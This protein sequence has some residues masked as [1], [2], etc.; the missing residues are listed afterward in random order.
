[1]PKRQDNLDV[2]LSSEDCYKICREVAAKL[3]WA[4]EEETAARGR[5]VCVEANYADWIK[6]TWP[7]EL[8]I[9][10]EAKPSAT[11]IVL[12]G[13]NRGFGPIQSRHLETQMSNFKNQLWLMA[14]EAST[15][16]SQARAPL[17][18]RLRE[19]GKLHEQGMLTD[20]EFSLAKRKLIES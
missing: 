6:G 3:N 1:M 19:L 14:N 17:A 13:A 4:V 10:L 9:L 5:L 15:D 12:K 16:T 11:N 18:S 20:E 8:E 2:S 7:V